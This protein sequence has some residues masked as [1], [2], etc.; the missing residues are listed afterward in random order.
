M[1]TD[2][3][4][5]ESTTRDVT[6]LL[7][8][9]PQ[10]TL[11][12][13]LMDAVVMVT[14]RGDLHHFQWDND[15]DDFVLPYQPI[16]VFAPQTD[17]NG[18]RWRELVNTLRDDEGYE[19]HPGEPRVSAVNFLLGDDT[20]VIGDSAGGLQ[21][22]LTL[23]VDDR[24]ASRIWKRFHRVRTLPPSSGAITAI[25]ASP[26]TKA[27][28]VVDADSHVRAINNTAKR[29]YAE[30]HAD[31][32]ETAVFNRKGDG[33]LAVSAEG[34]VHHWWV[35]APHSEVSWTSLF[36]KVWYESYPEP[37]FIWQ[38]SGG[39]DDVE[40]KL[41]LVPLVT[42]TIKGALYALLFAVPL[43]VLAAI[44]TSEFMHRNMRSILKP[45]MEVM[46]SLP[47]VVLGFLAALYFARAASSIMPTLICAA[48]IIPAVY[49][50]FGWVWQRCPPSFVGQFGYWRS[51]ALLF[52]L[53]ALGV[54]I[55]SVVGPRAEVF[56]FP[57][58]E[59]AN[60]S[61][62]DPVTFKPLN[63]EAAEA[64]AAGDFRNWTAGGA[65]LTQELDVAG[66]RLPEGW[67]IPGGHNLLVALLAIPLAL[68]LGWGSR[69]VARRMTSDGGTT[70]AERLR[71][72][73][74]GGGS[75]ASA[76]AV[77]ADIGFSL[78]FAAVLIAGGLALSYLLAPV[79]EAV[80]FAYDHPTAGHVTD[81]RRFITG[82][83]GWKFEQSNSL[84]V[85]FAMGFAVIPLIYTISEDALTTVPNQL[86]AASLACGASRWQTTMRVVMPAAISGIFSAIV[87][88][89]G[90][91]LG[92]TMIVV[93][94]AG[95]TP[96]MDMQPF[97]GFRS[98]SAAI[99][100]EMPEAPHG[101]TL[102]RT[103]F[104]AGLV[105][106]LM[107][108]SINTVAEIVRMR[109]RKRLSRL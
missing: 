73:L 69:F 39:T 101:G 94:A 91:A 26:I 9:V 42:G 8:G 36:G 45:T 56:L 38:S 55:A 1:M 93:M 23:Q 7:V 65:A 61:L 108:F 49:M 48:V 95:G 98:L 102:Y 43:A 74:E 22:W 57:S 51:T 84:V 68:L 29:V 40:P 78:A 81:F 107:A 60:P 14:P 17:E 11:V 89:L 70:P 104:L 52:A 103:L 90:R 76:R 47:S 87:I 34:E 18:E 16:S 3:L 105:L 66:R 15:A 4:Q 31:G 5:A 100:I 32:V 59:G 85:G 96:L 62:L 46:A 54:V 86:R 41:S 53:F 21:S 37:Q 72:R 6:S 25:N 58:V 75:P 12:N 92:E 80:F 35:D 28:L 99:A 71:R 97:N 88:G 44:Y 27:A 67:W 109:L 77:L 30:L 83:E 24:E 64:L 13:E 33:I 79:V 2:E 106:F 10:W 20:I 50:L 63:E 82:P 19:P